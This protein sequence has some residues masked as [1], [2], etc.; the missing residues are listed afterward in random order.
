M[1]AVGDGAAG[2]VG[3]ELLLL[4]SSLQAVTNTAMLT[5]RHSALIGGTVGISDTRNS[6]EG[7]E[8]MFSGST[9]NSHQIQTI[10]WVPWLNSCAG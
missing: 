7:W 8:S 9:D 1:E 2:A 4:V 10:S 5:A 3:A 6:L